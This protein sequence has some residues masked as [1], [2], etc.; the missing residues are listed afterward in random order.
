L[1]LDGDGQELGR[2]GYNAL[3]ETAWGGAV[4]QPFRFR[5]AERDPITGLYDLEGRPYA[6]WLGRTIDDLNE[7]LQPTRQETPIAPPQSAKAEWLAEIFRVPL[8]ASEDKGIDHGERE[9]QDPGP[10]HRPEPQSSSG[11]AR[12]GVGQ[13]AGLR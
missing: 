9:L 10:R 7:L 3:G 1:V 13:G 12:R 5:G 6:P 2:E 4:G 11:A 8:P